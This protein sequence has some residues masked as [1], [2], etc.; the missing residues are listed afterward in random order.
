MF[1]HFDVSSKSIFF[2]LC[3]I[4]PSHHRFVSIAFEKFYYSLIN[5]FTNET[6]YTARHC[7]RSVDRCDRPNRPRIPSDMR[8]RYGDSFGHS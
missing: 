4:A 7:V 1:R 3:A 2:L 6:K 5:Q 8:L